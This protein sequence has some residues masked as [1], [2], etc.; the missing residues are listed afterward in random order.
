LISLKIVLKQMYDFSFRKSF[1]YLRDRRGRDRMAISFTT[2]YVNLIYNYLWQSHLQL[3][4]AISF[5]TTYGNLIYNYLWQS[6]LQLP[7]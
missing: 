5:T 1:S 7:M 3:P 4:M 2:T 6:H